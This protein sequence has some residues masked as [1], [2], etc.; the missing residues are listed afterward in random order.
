M[1]RA[2]L[3]EVLSAEFLL[4]RILRD[5][6]KYQQLLRSC[7]EV[8]VKRSIQWTPRDFILQDMSLNDASGSHEGKE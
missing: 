8:V 3:A 6:V 2:V 4:R 5:S 1:Q 7:G